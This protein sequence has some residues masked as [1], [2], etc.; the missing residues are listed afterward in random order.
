MAP[1]ARNQHVRKALAKALVA[2]TALHVQSV[3]L[4]TDTSG[5][6]AFYLRCGFVRIED[7]HATHIMEL[8]NA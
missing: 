2:Q 5:G 7:V 8:V 6:D 3:R 4:S 1:A